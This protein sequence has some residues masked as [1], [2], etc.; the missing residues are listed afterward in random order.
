M[1][2][3][4]RCRYLEEHPVA[5]CT[6]FSGGLRT[7]RDCELELLCRGHEHVHC[8]HFMAR[9]AGERAMVGDSGSAP[10]VPGDSVSRRQEEFR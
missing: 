5:I 3:S 7:P 10:V 6:A 2:G 1:D 4:D 9:R 8:R